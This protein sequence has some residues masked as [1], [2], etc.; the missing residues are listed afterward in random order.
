MNINDD[1]DG[2][3]DD[4]LLWSLCVQKLFILGLHCCRQSRMH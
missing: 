3:D 4:W 2:D 1:D